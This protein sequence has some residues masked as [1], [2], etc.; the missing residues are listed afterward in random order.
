MLTDAHC[1]P[2]DLSRVF[3]QAEN[4]RRRFGVAAAA[5]ACDLEEFSHNEDL[6][7]KAAADGAAPLLPC[8]AVHPQFPALKKANI[9]EATRKELESCF[10]T[11]QKLASSGRISAVGECG[12][13][14]YNPA[15]RETEKIQD[16]IFA[17]HIETALRYNLP[18]VIHVRKALHK[19]FALSKTLAKCRA[20]IFHSWHA[21]FEEGQSLL[22]RGVNVYFSFGNIIL[23][24]HKRAMQACAYCPA[25]RL[26]TETDAP[27]IPRKGE[28]FSHWA[29]LPLIVESIAA[30]RR[31]AQSD[32]FGAKE[33][34]ARIENNF[35]DV[36]AG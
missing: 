33:L 11:L 22:R 8:F 2:F 9:N 17:A 5:S 18:V 10:E 3:P 6:A 23:N 14:F 21:S 29:D 12:F 25:Q 16:S 26:L 7:L 24:G 20:V 1:H 31:D 27:Y 28:N 15:F 4:E 32:V 36:F 19:I 35:W 34:E 30:L 13:D